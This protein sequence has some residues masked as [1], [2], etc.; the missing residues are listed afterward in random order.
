MKSK[1]IMRIEAEVVKALR[2][3]LIFL[4]SFFLFKLNGK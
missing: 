4:N 3:S 2:T 1:M